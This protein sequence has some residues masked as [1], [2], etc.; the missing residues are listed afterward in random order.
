MQDNIIEPFLK[1]WMFVWFDSEWKITFWQWVGLNNELSDLARKPNNI[2]GALQIRT[3]ASKKNTN[4][5]TSSYLLLCQVLVSIL[6][7]CP[8][9]CFCWAHKS[10]VRDMKRT[11]GGT[12]LMS[13]TSANPVCTPVF[14]AK[15]IYCAINLGCRVSLS[16]FSAFLLSCFGLKLINFLSASS[17]QEVF[18][19]TLITQTVWLRFPKGKIQ[20]VPFVIDLSFFH[21]I[22]WVH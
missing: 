14:W 2:V 7:P 16:T 6:L 15:S 4:A 22:L 8:H 17:P 11:M 5:C 3:F 20:L 9:S 10:L 19:S 21:M 1:W 13:S 12:I 18:M